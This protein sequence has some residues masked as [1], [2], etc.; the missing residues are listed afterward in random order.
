MYRKFGE[1]QKTFSTTW[2]TEGSNEDLLT[3]AFSPR[4]QMVNLIFQGRYA[5]I[6]YLMDKI[7]VR[8]GRV[9][10]P[11]DT[12]NSNVQE[13]K[14]VDGIQLP[15]GNYFLRRDWSSANKMGQDPFSYTPAALEEDLK[16]ELPVTN[17]RN[18]SD[19][20]FMA[21]LN[22]TN[23]IAWSIESP[24]DKSFADSDTEEDVA[25][26]KGFLLK[27]HE[28]LEDPV[29]NEDILSAVIDM[30]SMARWF[31]L[32]EFTQEC[33]GYVASNFFKVS[34]GKLYHA[35]PWDYAGSCTF[36]TDT[37]E[38]R[39]E[40]INAMSLTMYSV[41]RE[42]NT[43]TTIPACDESTGNMNTA[44]WWVNTMH[45]TWEI[46]ICNSGSYNCDKG[47]PTVTDMR[48]D[49]ANM[50]RIP[51]LQKEFWNLWD[52]VL[53]HGLVENNGSDSGDLFSTDLFAGQIFEP[54]RL[55]VT[56]DKR[57]WYSTLENTDLTPFALNIPSDICEPLLEV[58]LEESVVGNSSSSADPYIIPGQEW[59]FHTAY[60]N[61][62]FINFYEG[63]L[64]EAGPNDF[65]SNYLDSDYLLA[66]ER[67]YF[68]YRLDWINSQRPG[69]TNNDNSNTNE[70]PNTTF[71][72][73]KSSGQTNSDT[74]STTNVP[75]PSND[76]NVEGT[77]NTEVVSSSSPLA[78]PAVTS[79]R[80]I[81][82]VGCMGFMLL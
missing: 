44:G 27:L 7:E 15:K 66:K 39:D 40:L 46:G 49:F 73:A 17:Y 1:L 24:E 70:P 68:K 13:R 79:L 72:P 33:D 81:F 63:L 35:S 74:R 30:P 26:L 36:N 61:G 29:G 3:R 56:A 50:F 54:I 65:I 34:D 23:P 38:H 42:T 2:P 58:S 62:N 4:S 77:D 82:G 75:A 80:F 9:Y 31:L 51:A 48:Y 52:I 5:G 22:V 28:W 53:E 67:N 8:E 11:E 78:I 6:F 32:A 69:K 16:A 64:S 45:I 71:Y 43:Y 21:M 19:D 60:E 41:D 37:C 55:T 12:E 10:L 76:V 20:V 18:S 14:E 25:L 59:T 47:G 57:I